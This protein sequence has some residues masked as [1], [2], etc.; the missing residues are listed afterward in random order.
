MKNGSMQGLRILRMRVGTLGRARP[1]RWNND[2]PGGEGVEGLDRRR[3]SII[4]VLN[5]AAQQQDFKF[6]VTARIS[7]AVQ[8]LISIIPTWAPAFLL[9][10]RERRAPEQVDGGGSAGLWESVWDS[11][12]Q[13]HVSP[14]ATVSHSPRHPSNCTLF[15]LIL[16]LLISP[17]SPYFSVQLKTP[18][19][20]R[21]DEKYCNRQ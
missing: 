9:W 8:I 4:I 17:F 12:K 21:Y 10:T 7:S 14:D 11:T 16:L 19:A 1:I 2:Q 13:L 3:S 5:F 18:I 6:C 15:S 20:G